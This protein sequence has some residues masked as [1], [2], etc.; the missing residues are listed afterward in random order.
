M[1]RLWT[2][3]ALVAALLV[4]PRAGAVG[5]GNIGG[6]L[7]APGDD[8]IRTWIGFPGLGVAFHTLA[9]DGLEIGP[10]FDFEYGSSHGVD[11]VVVSLLVGCELKIRMYE[12]ED[13][14]IALVADPS[15]RFKFYPD[16]FQF[17]VRFAPR[18]QASWSFSD[19][20]TA[21]F[22]FG[23]PLEILF[24]DDVFIMSIPVAFGGGLEF[25]V[26]EDVNLYFVSDIGP[27][28]LVVDDATDIDIYYRGE[29]G[30]EFR[31]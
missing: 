22:R 17:G 31:F 8:S 7:L 30:A 18:V 19:A 27:N 20:G 5:W 10:H 28:I 11:A 29:V 26:T 16:D 4:A 21:I 6:K 23:L 9:T 12:K 13:W 24:D 1:K 14:A 3:T 25:A 15:A 2:V